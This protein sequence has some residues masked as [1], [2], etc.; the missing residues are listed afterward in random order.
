[1]PEFP[2]RWLKQYPTGVP[3]NVYEHDEQTLLDIIDYSCQQYAQRQCCY[4]L[5]GALSYAELYQHSHSFSA[6]LIQQGL[7]K[8]DRVALMMPNLMQFV[9]GMVGVLRAGGVVV[10]VNP[11][12][13]ARELEQLVH[14]AQPR[15]ILV[16]TPFVA[17]LNQVP[18]PDSLQQIIITDLG[19][20][21]TWPRRLLI[22]CFARWHS[23]ELIR[24][25]S[26]V[27]Q[28]IRFQ[29]ALEQGASFIARG[30]VPTVAIDPQDIAFLLYTGGTTGPPK[31]VILTH[32]NLVA[33][34]NQIAHW[35]QGR[36]LPGKET[37]L[38]ALPLYHVFSLTGNCLLFLKL[39]GSNVLIPDARKTDTIVRAFKQHKI[40]A[41]TG[42]NTLFM[43]LLEHPQFQ[44]LNFN[45]LRLVIGGGTAVSES[46]ALRWEALTKQPLLQAYGLTETSPAVCINPVDGQHINSSIG[47]P[48]P[49]TEVAIF[50]SDGTVLAPYEHGEICVRGPQVT[51]GYYQREEATHQAFFPESFFRTGDIGYM[52][53]QGYVFLKER[54]ADIINISGFNV[55]PSEIEAVLEAYPGVKAAAVVGIPCIQTGQKIKAYVQSTDQHL[56]AQQLA[57]HCAQ[58]L[59]AYKCPKEIELCEQLPFSHVGKV[60]KRVLRGDS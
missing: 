15:F 51:S 30:V 29:Q 50:A 49:S 3:H 2:M 16:A 55:Y 5:G 1:M 24:P 53:A 9:I 32:R 34:L 58:Q 18:Y 4:C 27:G 11:L 41:F 39:G 54:Q 43:R 52:D 20:L 28:Y 21:Q 56:T 47:L 40:S 19:D 14:D 7:Q 57:Q 36:L 10:T 33:N 60:L 46:V 35:V 6:W 38:T 22:N 26:P 8:G 23:K 44:Q 17:T 37:V 31:G 13:T 59:A 48:L 45:S 25:A 42:V 12:Y